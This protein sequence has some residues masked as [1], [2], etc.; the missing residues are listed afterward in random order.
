[1]KFCNSGLNSKI[2]KKK[3]KLISKKKLLK[4]LFY[5]I[6]VI[7]SLKWKSGDWNPWSEIETFL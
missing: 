2:Y 5:K 1:M 3:K 4:S 7:D 6:S